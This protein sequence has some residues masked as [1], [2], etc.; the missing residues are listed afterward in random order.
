MRNLCEGNL[1]NQEIVS[2]LELQGVASNDELDS[3]G[4]EVVIEEGKPRVR[5]KK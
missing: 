4:M 1:L 5:R 3:M 2:S